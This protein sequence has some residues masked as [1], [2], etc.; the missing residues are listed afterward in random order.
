LKARDR[1]LSRVSRQVLTAAA[2]LSNANASFGAGDAEQPRAVAPAIAAKG[3]TYPV[4]TLAFVLR[5]PSGPGV[6][7]GVEPVNRLVLGGQLASWLLVSEAS[8]Y[9]RGILYRGEHDDFTAG[10]R[11]HRLTSLLGSDEQ[12][13][14]E[15]RAS[16]EVG[17]EHTSGSMVLGVDVATAFFRSGTSCSCASVLTGELRLGTR[18]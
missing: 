8:V 7:F 11:L 6:D 2:L 13:P 3:R 10:L 16:V 15:W 5:F 18:W 1:G 14:N 12:S 4:S 9:T 17:Y